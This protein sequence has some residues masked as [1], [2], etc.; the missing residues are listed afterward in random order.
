[1]R[2]YQTILIVSLILAWSLQVVEI[3][4]DEKMKDGSYAVRRSSEVR[5]SLLPLAKDEA[6]L[7]YFPLV[8][9]EGD[10]KEYL[11]LAREPFVPLTL[12]EKPTKMKDPTNRTASWLLLML[13]SDAAEKLE[14]FTKANIGGRAAVVVGEKAVSVHKIREVI[15][16]GK[17]QISRCGDDGCEHL[18]VLLQSNVRVSDNAVLRYLE[19][20]ELQYE[21]DGQK[22][23]V[24]AA[25]E[26]ILLLPAGELAKKRYGEYNGN[27]GVWDLPT[28][29]ERHF[30]PREQGRTMGD[31]FYE[32]IKAPEVKAEVR[33][34]LKELRT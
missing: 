24:I 16:D 21:G 26:D 12:K 18:Y 13:T 30:V 23:N 6:L 27:K 3:R 32:E 22:A 31:R 29:I 34:I 11:V 7:E 28:L 1:M 8:Q 10:A 2:R 5:D 14:E 19:S 33:R 4:A 17:L 20:S 25:L 9:Q 15:R